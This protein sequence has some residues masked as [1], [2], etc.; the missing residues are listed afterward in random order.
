[1]LLAV[2]ADVCSILS[3]SRNI[4]CAFRGTTV[5]DDTAPLLANAPRKSRLYCAMPPRPPKASP[6]RASSLGN[7]FMR[8]ALSQGRP[9]EQ[10]GLLPY[11]TSGVKL[12]PCS[13]VGSPTLPRL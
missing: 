3:G 2:R 9:L 6:T 8:L 1:M 12:A 11:L 13:G 7:G 10:C 5:I 4:P